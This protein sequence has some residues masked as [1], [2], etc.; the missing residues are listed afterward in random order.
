KKCRMA[1]KY[2][3]AEYGSANASSDGKWHAKIE[4]SRTWASRTLE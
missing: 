2:A 4:W 1:W 3:K